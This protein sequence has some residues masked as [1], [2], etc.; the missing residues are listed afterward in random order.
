MLFFLSLSL[1]SLCLF[2]LYSLSS[3]LTSSR[4]HPRRLRRV[5]LLSRADQA[6]PV[7]GVLLFQVRG[8]GVLVVLAGSVLL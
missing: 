4:L 8:G 6:S 5:R 1:N 2:P 7:H 3:S